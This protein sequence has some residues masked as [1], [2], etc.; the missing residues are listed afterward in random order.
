MSSPAT[1]FEALRDVIAL[2][3]NVISPDLRLRIDACAELTL[4]THATLHGDE[5][6]IVAP[7]TVKRYHL[8]EIPS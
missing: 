3:E 7:G 8:V 2:P 6:R 5:P 1:V 4:V